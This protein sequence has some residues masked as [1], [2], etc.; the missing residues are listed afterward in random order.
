MTANALSAPVEAARF[1][2]DQD[3]VVELVR[4]L[5]RERHDEGPTE[6]VVALLCQ[7]DDT[8]PLPTELR[9]EGRAELIGPLVAALA[10]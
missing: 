10:V 7:R 6:T 3:S 1:S 5:L 9:I 2:G 8:A 4:D